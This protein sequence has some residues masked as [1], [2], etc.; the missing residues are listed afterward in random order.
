MRNAGWGHQGLAR[1]GVKAL[2]RAKGPPAP[3]P[4]KRLLT[5]H[6]PSSLPGSV[7]RLACPAGH[8]AAVIGD[9]AELEA[10]LH[11]ARS[12][13]GRSIVETSKLAMSFAGRQ[14]LAVDFHDNRLLAIEDGDHAQRQAHVG[15][16]DIDAADARNTQ[17]LVD[18]VD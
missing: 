5:R 4:G 8:Q 2:R 11:H 9:G 1:S 18:V 15:R 7:P 14:Q 16:S 6:L 12:I 17:N 3:S 10:H 13:S